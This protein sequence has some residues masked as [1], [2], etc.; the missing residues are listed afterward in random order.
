MKAWRIIAAC[1]VAIGCLPAAAHARVWTDSTGR[2]TVEADL[3][4]FDDETVVLKRADHELAAVPID[5]LSEKDREF[6]KSKG[7]ADAA[8]QMMDAMQT[9][10]LKDGTKLAGR[11][12]AYCMRDI[13]IQRRRGML[14][15]NDRR[16]ESLPEFYQKLLPQIVAHFEKLPATDRR[17]LDAWVLQQRGQP[18]TFHLEGV[19]LE[20]ENND[21]YGVPFFLFSEADL[22]LLKPGWDEWVAAMEMED[23][24]E[25]EDLAFLLRSL[26]AARQRDEKVQREIALMQLKLQAVTAGVTSLWEVTLY[27]ADGQGGPPQWVVVTG[28]DS[29]QAT[30]SALQ[31]NPG[32][33]AGPVRKVSGF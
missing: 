1:W 9:W 2:Y 10:T 15:V 19:I 30:A 11:M 33:V 31:Q 8:K 20:L 6:L 21:E 7:A 12:V 13:T 32:F 4:S 26:G 14:F 5:K 27:P 29:R 28:R 18:R 23:Y 16:F 17:S 25:Q 24:D 3:V 22:K